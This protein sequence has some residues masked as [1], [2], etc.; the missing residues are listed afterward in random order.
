MILSLPSI[1]SS[2]PKF[3]HL[4]FKLA[5]ELQTSPYRPS[6][7]DGL[8]QSLDSYPDLVGSLV[9][10]Q[11]LLLQPT[12]SLFQA[13]DLRF[14]LVDN[15]LAC[16][17]LLLGMRKEWKRRSGGKGVNVRINFLDVKEDS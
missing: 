10:P 4:R 12:V 7:A 8:P 17:S 13:C 1:R 14:N 11:H 16:F 2:S 6:N 5:S 3:R 15:S 9:T